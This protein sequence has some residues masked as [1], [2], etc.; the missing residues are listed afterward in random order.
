M[1][2]TNVEHIALGHILPC[3]D[4]QSDV[5][6]QQMRA[7]NV[8]GGITSAQKKETKLKEKKKNLLDDKV[9]EEIKG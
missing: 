5:S 2:G 7:F 9:R 4:Y 6:C 3:F 1:A 8:S